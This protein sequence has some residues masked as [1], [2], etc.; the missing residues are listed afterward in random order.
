MRT[1]EL[2]ARRLANQLLAAPRSADPVE[3]TRWLGAVQSQEYAQS[4]WALGLRTQGA[5]AA[6]V[7][8]AID[9]GAILRTWPMRGTIHL[10]PAED[11]RWMV[12]LLA[13]RPMRSAAGTFRKI[14]LTDDVFARA[15]DV[16]TG[17][18]R[19]GRQLPRKDLYALLTKAGID[20]SASP[21]GGRG[22][23]ILGYLSHTG[24]LCIGPVRRGQPMFVL[25]DEWAPAPR[26]QAEPL[27]ELATRYFTSHGPATVRDF[28]WWSGLT[29]ADAK[30]AIELAGPALADEEHNGE[31]YWAATGRRDQAAPDGAYLLP[32]FDEYTVAYKDRSLLADGGPQ[33]KSDKLNSDLLNPVMLLDGRAAGLWRRVVGGKSVQIS[34]AP[35]GRLGRPDRP[36]WRLLPSGTRRSSGCPPRSAGPIQTACAGCAGGDGRAPARRWG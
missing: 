15:A 6:S 21:N 27:A 29:Q 35:Y 20:C 2:L 1:E 5:S 23:H 34:V 31:R 33:A 8:A 16:V 18:L 19:G 26:Q 7:Q 4:L 3:V 14:G 28:A 10:V 30:R 17:A 25:L 22:N 12:T 24:L 11:A 32:A 13:S 9:R 36:G